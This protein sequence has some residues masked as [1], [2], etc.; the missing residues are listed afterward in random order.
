[1]SRYLNKKPSDHGDFSTSF[2]DLVFGLLFVFFLLAIAMVFNRPEVSTFQKKL[3]E[4][5]KELDKQAETISKSRI[6]LAEE[7]MKIERL[8]KRVLEKTKP[9]ETKPAGARPLQLP[10]RSGAIKKKANKVQATLDKLLRDYNKLQN[11]MRSLETESGANRSGLLRKLAGFKARNRELEAELEQLREQNIVVERHSKELQAILSKVKGILKQKGLADILAQVNKMED[12][13]K[14]SERK[15]RSGEDE[16]FNDYKLWVAYDPQADVLSAEL[17][18]GEKLLDECGSID[19]G[20]LLDMAKE[21]TEE[22]KDISVDYT[23]LEKREHQPRLFL[24]I[25]PDTAYGQV[26]ELLKTLRK[27]IVVSIVPWEQ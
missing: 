10:A 15:A 9:A 23:E 20:E 26:Q 24:R 13:L 7:K 8:K 11:K 4:M 1:M 25:H 2:A 12:A 22:Y 27:G 19:P 6:E 21:L 5:Q 18:E 16:L 17:W 3:D 14:E